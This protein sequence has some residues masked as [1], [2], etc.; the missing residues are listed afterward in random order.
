M[1]PELQ[2]RVQRY[3]WDKASDYYEKSWADQLKPAQELLIEMADL[4]TGEKVIDIACGTGLVTFKVAEKVGT[5]GFVLGSDISDKMIETSLQYSVYKNQRNANFQRMD[6]EELT[7]EDNYFDA[8]LSA[9]GLMYSPDPLTACKEMNRVTKPNGRAV[10]AV[11]GERKNCG[12]AEIFPIVDAR[13]KS[14]VCPLFFQLGV[15][16]NLKFTF[17]QVGFTNIR[18]ERISTTLYYETAEEASTAV[19]S[20]GP[21]AMAYSR[22]DQTTKQEVHKEY[23]SSI[24]QFKNGKGYNIPGEF[25]VAAGYKNN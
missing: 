8:S 4:K 16:D 6:A 22:F 20:G 9:L 15:Q 2:K 10:A 11:W 19:F 18:L 21:V 17:E 14:D 12:W 3:G 5:E 23:L 1:S 24:E 25:V 7:A 13:V